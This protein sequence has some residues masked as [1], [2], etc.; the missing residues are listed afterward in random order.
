MSLA[1]LDLN[2]VNLHGKKRHDG[3]STERQLQRGFDL[4]NEK[5]PETTWICYVGNQSTLPMLKRYFGD[6][7]IITRSRVFMLMRLKDRHIAEQKAKDEGG[8]KA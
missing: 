2:H 8:D 6:R 4:L 7:V 3:G 1:L 5:W